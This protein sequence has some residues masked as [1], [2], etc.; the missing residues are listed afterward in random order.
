M[1]GGPIWWQMYLLYLAA[2]HFRE[3]EGRTKTTNRPTSLQNR[4]AKMNQS[5]FHA[6]IDANECH[7]DGIDSVGYF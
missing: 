6:F 1:R 2:L 7:C 5:T 4:T 3:H